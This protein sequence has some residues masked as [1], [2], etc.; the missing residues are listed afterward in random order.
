MA[1]TAI[2]SIAAQYREAFPS[3]EAL[4]AEARELFPSGVTHDGRYL[5]P[6]PVYVERSA[7]SKKYT[8]EG[9]E[10]VDCWSGHGALLLGH[11]H[12]A[13]VEAVTRQM[14]RGT[15]WSACHE[16][17][18]EWARR[19]IRMVPSAERVRFTSSGTEATLMALRV[20]RIVTGRSPEI[21]RAH[22]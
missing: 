22:V 21:G 17:E 12:P 2:A 14:P 15:H 7:G 19:V 11:A 3:S 1:D 9:R 18:M 13:V 5:R 20:A 16:L 10:L 4:Y 8:V 6:F